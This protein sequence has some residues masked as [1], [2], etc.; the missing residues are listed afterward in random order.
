MSKLKI[1]KIISK[2]DLTNISF[3]KKPIVF[4]PMALDLL[5]YGHIRILKKSKKLGTV[6]VGLMTDKGLKSYKR[7]PIFTY[8]LRKEILEEIKSVD[9]IIPL[10][11]IIY[12]EISKLIKPDY[13]VHGTDWKKGNQKYERKKL[14]ERKK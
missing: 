4:V 9:Y 7:N 12:S 8:K 1:K 3:L 6:V 2:K 11:G 13:F 5:H 14:I 10:N